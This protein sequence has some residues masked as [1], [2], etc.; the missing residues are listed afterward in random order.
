MTASVA[1]GKLNDEIGQRLDELAD[2]LTARGA[3]QRRIGL[4]RRGARAV[5]ALSR[6]VD[7]ILRAEGLRGLI[8]IPSIGE[9]LARVV[10]RLA[11]T[12]NLPLLQR[13][14]AAG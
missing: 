11:V 14:R 10:R 5:R 3:A 7:V 4:Y 2:L 9:K 8:R 1:A 12:G 6:P 13:L